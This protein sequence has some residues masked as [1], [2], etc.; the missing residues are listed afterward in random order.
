MTTVTTEWSPLSETR[1][2]CCSKAMSA[3]FLC[4]PT[5]ALLS[6]ARFLCCTQ[7]CRHSNGFSHSQAV[8]KN[9]GFPQAPKHRLCLLLVSHPW[10]EIGEGLWQALSSQVTL[11]APSPMWRGAEPKS[12]SGGGRESVQAPLHGQ[13]ASRHSFQFSKQYA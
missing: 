12:H 8:P 11:V 7:G 5:S 2:C 3:D 13:D 6:K 1:T 9:T 4:P 10:E